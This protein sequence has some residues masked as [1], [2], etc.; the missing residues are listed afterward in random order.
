MLITKYY[1]LTAILSAI[2]IGNYT[3]QVFALTDSTENKREVTMDIQTLKKYMDVNCTVGASVGLIDHGT[4]TTFSYGKTSINKNEIVSENT[5]F[6]IGSITKVFTTLALMDLITKGEAQLD[7]PI[8]LHLP[9]VKVPEMDGKKITLLHLATHHSGLPSM[10]TN[11]NPKNPLNLFEDYSVEN[12]YEFLNNYNLEKAPG[13]QFE[14]SNVGMGLL[15]HILC[16]K[17]GKSYEQIISDSISKK[18]GMENTG[19]SLTQEMRKGFADGHH[20]GQIAEHWNFTQ[21]FAGAGAIRS[22]VKDMI[23]FLAANMELLNSPLT[24]LLKECHKQQY[25]TGSGINIGLGWLLYHSDYA[26]IIWH[27]GGTSG[28]RSFL[29]FNLATQKGVVILSN[30]TEGWPEQLG[31]SLLDP[32]NHKNSI[33]YEDSP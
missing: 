10:P 4:I 20:L 33:V 31:L 25:S 30:S 26:D 3:L 13:V 14:Y 6:E 21:A 5:I 28:F 23:Q 19:I 16:L 7:N 9:E 15:G 24:D 1:L 29:G 11:F 32:E 17:V 8:E 22:N 2:L 27:N 18:L 12:L